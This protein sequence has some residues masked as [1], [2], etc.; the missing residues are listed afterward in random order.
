MLLFLFL[1][2][3]AIAGNEPVDRL[4]LG[5]RSEKADRR[6]AALERF[7]AD[8]S[9][10]PEDRRDRVARILATMLD[11]DRRPELRGLAARALV[12][13][14]ST[15]NDF[16]ILRRLGCEHPIIAV[17]AHAMVEYRERSMT[18]GCDAYLAKPLERSVLSRV[19][20]ETLDRGAE[21][22]AGAR[23]QLAGSSRHSRK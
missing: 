8:P 3:P 10:V 20:R 2:V 7:I 9:L 18:A 6:R 17:T 22:R 11:K 23:V 15:E 21:R 14:R 19:V 1:T 5:L 13:Y 12:H 4:L 16:R